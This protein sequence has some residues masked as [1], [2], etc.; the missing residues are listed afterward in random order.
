MY[1]VWTDLCDD[2]DMKDKLSSLR[3]E[4]RS[5]GVIQL[6][7]VAKRRNSIQHRK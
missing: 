3:D 7:S 1:F 5:K 6:N 4:I 2:P